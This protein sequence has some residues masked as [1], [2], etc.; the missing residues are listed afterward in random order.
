MWANSWPTFS[1]SDPEQADDE[2]S[3]KV[4]I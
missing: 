4:C 3:Q 2:K 1:A